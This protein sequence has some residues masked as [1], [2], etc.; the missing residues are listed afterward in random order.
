V[1]M[2]PIMEAV[3]DSGLTAI[4]QVME[5]V[6]VKDAKFLIT[7]EE[8]KEFMKAAHNLY[9]VDATMLTETKTKKKHAEF[10]DF[11]AEDQLQQLVRFSAGKV[12]ARAE[13][14]AAAKTEVDDEKLI[15]MKRSLQNSTSI[16]E[17]SST[18]KIMIK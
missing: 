7:L 4:E 16:S 17:G 2:K 10:V 15:S 1:H 14:Q 5:L 3:A 6:A 13:A 18:K 12:V 11:I 8:G 9:E